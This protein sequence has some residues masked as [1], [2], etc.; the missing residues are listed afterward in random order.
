MRAEAGPVARLLRAVERGQLAEAE[1]AA[2]ECDVVPLEGALGICILSRLRGD[3]RAE[4]A[5][6]RFCAG[7][8]S[9]R[10]RLT[11]IHCARIEA[12]DELLGDRPERAVGRIALALRQAGLEGEA[13]FV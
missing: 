8:I 12:A 3:E 10:P 7:L 4:R 9:G 5:L 6:R 1:A 11:L 13:A 2:R